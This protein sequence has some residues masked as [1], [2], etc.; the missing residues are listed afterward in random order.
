MKIHLTRIVLW[1]LVGAMLSMG[2]AR[3]DVAAMGEGANLSAG[4]ALSGPVRVL[5]APRRMTDQPVLTMA[6]GGSCC[7]CSEPLPM[8]AEATVAGFVRLPRV[9]G[10]SRLA[11]LSFP[12]PHDPPRS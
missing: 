12:P 6:A 2:Q 3:A 11:A 1:L 5:V 10:P 9:F 8:A 4:H 7:V